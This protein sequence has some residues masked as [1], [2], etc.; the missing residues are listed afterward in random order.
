M[1]KA[2]VL[3]QEVLAE[4]QDFHRASM[5]ALPVSDPADTVIQ[6]V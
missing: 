3:V 4:V 6:E 5:A 1:T 2:A